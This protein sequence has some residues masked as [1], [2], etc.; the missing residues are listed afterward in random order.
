MMGQEMRDA[1]KWSGGGGG[2]EA[3]P[4]RARRRARTRSGSRRACWRTR[5]SRTRTANVRWRMTWR[6]SSG[7]RWAGTPTRTT[8]PS[9]IRRRARRPERAPSLSPLP[10]MAPLPSEGRRRRDGVRRGG[11]LDPGTG[12][13]TGTGTGIGTR[14]YERV[15]VESPARAVPDDGPGAGAG[16]V[17]RGGARAGGG[18]HRAAAGVPAAARA[19]A[20]AAEERGRRGVE[21]TYPGTVLLDEL[22]DFRS[23]HKQSINLLCTSVTLR[24][25][26]VV[27]AIRPRPVGG[28]ASVQV[29]QRDEFPLHL[30]LVAR[31]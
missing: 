14:G 13:G 1:R 23:H 31:V 9:R 3:P 7:R 4:G 11:G 17:V 21:G 6:T 25:M 16:D 8:A 5:G 10:G 15:P 26:V 22:F 24:A 27:L 19:R 2:S 12:I 29:E 18:A 30:R 28:S 20:A